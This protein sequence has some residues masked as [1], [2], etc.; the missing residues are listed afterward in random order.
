MYCIKLINTHNTNTNINN[1]KMDI[2][3]AKMEMDI[4]KAK[5]AIVESEYKD[6]QKTH[7]EISKKMR[8][9]ES[10]KK[11]LSKELK[12]LED[13]IE[14]ENI[15]ANV[16]WIEGVETLSQQELVSISTGMDQ[17]DYRKMD[18]INATSNTELPRWIDLERLVKEVIEFKKQYPGWILERIQ[19]SGQ[20]DTFPP[21]TF[22]K[23]TYKSPQGHFMSYGGIELL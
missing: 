7:N 8:L 23:F 12:R 20:H 2:T 15:L 17:T 13:I 3:E 10:A 14:S 18:L 1:L 16:L 6:H 9:C 21:Q 19:K 4:L 22:Y 5:L 11:N